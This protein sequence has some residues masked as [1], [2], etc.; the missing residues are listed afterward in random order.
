MSGPALKVVPQVNLDEFERRLRAA[1]APAGAQE[2]PLDELARLVGLDIHAVKP[3][4]DPAPGPTPAAPARLPHI[5]EPLKEGGGFD[6]LLRVSFGETK[7]DEDSSPLRGSLEQETPAQDIDPPVEPAPSESVQDEALELAADAS[8]PP[9]RSG[10]VKLTMG[11]LIGL[12]AAGLVAAWAVKGAPG[13][14]K[15]PPVILAVDGPTK[16]Q[17]PTQEYDRLAERL[18]L[19]PPEGS[20]QQAGSGQTRLQRGAACRPAAGSP[21]GDDAIR[22]DGAPCRRGDGSGAGRARFRQADRRSGDCR[23]DRGAAGCSR[24]VS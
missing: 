4:G 1:G 10:R 7:T 13:L 2:D 12:G 6:R 15:T 20:D 5:D 21:D 11:V 24:A 23:G 9:R 14:P 16:V 3:A 17:P 18:G 19:H 8:P 22:G